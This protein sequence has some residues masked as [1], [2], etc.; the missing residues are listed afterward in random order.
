MDDQ[1]IE[2]L[3][4]LSMDATQ[5]EREKSPVLETGYDEED[6]TWEVIVRF[7]GNL[8]EVV[9]P[10]WQVV[11]LSGGYAIVTLPA[12]EVGLLA[13]L[14]QIE[15]VEKPKR[16]YFEVDQG[17]AAS[18]ISAVQTPEMGLFG[19]GVLVAVIDSGIDYFHPDFRNEDGSSRIVALWDQTERA[20][21]TPPDGFTI[22][23]EYTKE[24]LNRYSGRF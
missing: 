14:P 5:E 4:N 8:E 2:N 9:R 15:Y 11:R 22:G 3:L 16:L 17:R 12:E 21:G 20:V 1:K 19:E 23:A 18:C 24:D 7:S 10:S 13:A 6:D